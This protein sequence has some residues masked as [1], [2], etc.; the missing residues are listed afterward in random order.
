[1]G[2]SKH[3][4]IAR[5]LARKHKADY[6]EGPGPDVK[7]KN[8]VI[9]VASHESDLYSSIDQVKRFQKPKYIATTPD[10][11]KKAKEVTKGTGIGVMGPKGTIEKKAKTTT[12]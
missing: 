10:L 8:R 2:Q 9:E 3:D 11:V 7:A 12:Q 6:N 5:Y 1:M 4:E